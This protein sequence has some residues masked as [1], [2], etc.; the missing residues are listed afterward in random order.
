MVEIKNHDFDKLYW[1]TLRDG[2]V[3]L[4]TKNA[5]AGNLSIVT[6]SDRT[7]IDWNSFSIGAGE[8]TQFV[9]PNM[10]SAVSSDF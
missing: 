8:L 3:R 9:Q 10:D 5:D 6:S 7:V 1:V 2:N 4:A